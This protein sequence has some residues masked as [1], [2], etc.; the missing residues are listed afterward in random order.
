MRS[1]I[2]QF[3]RNVVLAL[4]LLLPAF[5]FFY[6]STSSDAAVYFTFVKQ[7]NQLP[8]SF[9]P[10]RVSFGATSPLYVLLNVPLYALFGERWFMGNWL[11]NQLFLV[12]G[13]VWL[14][15]ALRGQTRTL[16]AV[17]ALTLTLP[18]LFITAAQG[19]E[20]PL[21]FMAMCGVLYLLSRERYLS[22][23]ALSGLLYL[24]RPEFVLL[25]LVVWGYAWLHLDQ[26]ALVAAVGL[27]SWLPAGAYHAYMW[28]FTGA[29][30]PSSL[31]NR[32]SPAVWVERLTTTIEQLANP[33]AGLIILAAGAMLWLWW[34]GE[35]RQQ[36]FIMGLTAGLMGFILLGLPGVHTLRYLLLVA[37][38]LIWLVV[39]AF[40]PV[41][42]HVPDVT[43]LLALVLIVLYATFPL[44]PAPTSEPREEMLYQSLAKQLNPR[45]TPAAGLLVADAAGQYSLTGRVYGLDGVVGSEWGGVY[46]GRED[47]AHFVVNQQINVLV[48]SLTFAE[49][50]DPLLVALYQHHSHTAVGSH[51][52]LNQSQWEKIL[53]NEAPGRWVAVYQK[54][55]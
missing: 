23:L 12:V 21:G 40:R 24:I 8:M 31:V 4:L 13:L 3:L 29:F 19:Y 22:V 45:L 30:F 37:P 2:T 55:D 39:V 41:A 25:S 14:T 35:A 32:L 5:I 54:V 36:G 16:L 44:F 1:S 50:K 51:F 42:L 38:L 34:R 33:L 28:H 48:V 15:Q 7:F 18:N 47:L 27:L 9:Q 10:G 26:L 49:A 46:S 11:I 17:V 52:T 43:R 53:V 20:T 6:G